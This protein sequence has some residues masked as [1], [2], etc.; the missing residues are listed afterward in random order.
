MA[1]LDDLATPSITEMGTDEAIELLRSIRLSRRIPTKKV[2][3]I[4][5]KRAKAAPK[6]DAN[7]ASELLKI[8]TGG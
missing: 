5:K 6:V 3:K 8:L 1:D 2:T 7:Q 4:T